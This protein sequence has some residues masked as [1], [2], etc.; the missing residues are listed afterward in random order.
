MQKIICF[1]NPHEENGYL[2]NWALTSFSVE[3]IRFSSM[4]QF[5]MF[6]K[7]NAFHDTK[8]AA[9]IL[10]TDD[11]AL[12]KRLGREVANYSESYWNGIRQIVVYQGLLAKFSQNPDLLVKLKQTGNAIL[13]ECAVHDRIWA[14]GLSIQD[15]DRFVPSTWKGKNLLGYSLMMVREYL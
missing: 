12:V 6:Q 14:T 4:E 9:K 3:G 7:A 10:Q 13:A 1:H 5:M 2:S 11:V 15:P 8:T